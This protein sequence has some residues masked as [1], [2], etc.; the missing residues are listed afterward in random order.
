MVPWQL[1]CLMTQQ[2]CRVN[3][4]SA[5]DFLLIRAHLL[6]SNKTKG[7]IVKDKKILFFLTAMP[8]S[9]MQLP[10]SSISMA[11]EVPFDS[12]TKE[13]QAPPQPPAPVG[14]LPSCLKISH[15]TT[16]QSEENT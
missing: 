5:N 15:F 3:N 6:A 2:I 11:R 9:R 1:K 8:Q 14:F 13:P 16:F 7:S 4:F 10:M 12:E